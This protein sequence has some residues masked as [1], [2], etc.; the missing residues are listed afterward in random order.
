MKTMSEIFDAVDKAQTRQDKINT[1]R[2]NNCFALKYL[3]T[4]IYSPAIKFVFDKVPK[5]K[6]SGVPD[7]MGYTS[8][9]Q[10]LGRAYLFEQGNTKVDPNLSLKR[11]EELLLQ[12]LE[13]LEDR[14][15]DLFSN[16]IEKRPVE[17]IDRD[18]VKE[19]FPQIFTT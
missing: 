7:G 2:N 9:H 1:L 12:I 17:G 6:R 13:A 4:G 8:I 5:F 15:A 10:E 19:A 11:K 3:L 14:E 18:L 16:M